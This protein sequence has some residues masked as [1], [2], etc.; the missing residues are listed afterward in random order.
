MN[1]RIRIRGQT[2]GASP[3]RR[4]RDDALATPS[5]GPLASADFA[6][7]LGRRSAPEPTT[8]RQQATSFAR[9][10]LPVEESC[11][12]LATEVE[13]SVE[14]RGH[15]EERLERPHQ[16]QGHE[17]GAFPGELGVEGG[18]TQTFVPVETM[19]E[20]VEFAL[21]VRDARGVHHLQLGVTT[22]GGAARASYDIQLRALGEGRI[23]LK[24]RSVG[25]HGRDALDARREL[26]RRLRERGLEVVEDDA[27]S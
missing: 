5:S 3:P 15:G 10:Q 6:D 25:S 20:V 19:S 14:A 4:G 24:V 2:G 13:P 17:L 16:R 11:E 8:R 18:L 9:P 27:G 22:G 12:S 26:V 1:E 7:L 23:A 21:L